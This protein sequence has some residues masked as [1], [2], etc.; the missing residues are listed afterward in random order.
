MAPLRSAV[1]KQKGCSRLWSVVPSAVTHR[2]TVVGVSKARGYVLHARAGGQA[3]APS[4]G[5]KMWLLI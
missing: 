1:K 5:P 3:P 2:G 4:E